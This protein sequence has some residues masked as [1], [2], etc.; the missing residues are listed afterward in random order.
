MHSVAKVTVRN[1]RISGE[2]EQTATAQ[3]TEIV[4]STNKSFVTRLSRVTGRAISNTVVINGVTTV[5]GEMAAGP[6]KPQLLTQTKMPRFER[7]AAFSYLE[8]GNEGLL[9]LP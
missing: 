3:G 7:V 4:V 5:D 8:N 6:G 1:D 2:T 9:L